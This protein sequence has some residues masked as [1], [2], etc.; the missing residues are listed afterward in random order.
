MASGNSGRK[1][2]LDVL[3]ILAS[4][5]VCYN[6]AHGFHY[7]L[8]QAAD[9]S[10]MSWLLVFHSVLIRINIPL[11]FMISGALLFGKEESWKVVL[12]KRVWRFFVLITGASAV[13][14]VVM[15]WGSLSWQDFVYSYLRGTVNG[16]HWYLFAYLGLLLMLPFLRR[17]AAGLTKTDIL[18]LLIMKLIHTAVL[19]VLNFAL[20]HWG[21]GPVALSDQLQLPLIVLDC[22]FYP[23]L[24]YYLAEKVSPEIIGK[25]QAVALIA[26]YV[27]GSL[28]STVVT[29]AQGMTTG[30]TQDYLGLFNC[31]SAMAVFL[32]VR[33]AFEKITV[34][35]KVQ[36][37]LSAVSGA[38]VGIYLLEPMVAKFLYVPFFRFFTWE[39][40][41]MI[42]G[43]L[44]WTVV[45]MATGLAVTWLLR[46]IPGVKR[47][48]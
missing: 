32:L 43:S 38:V 26:L 37:A 31:L 11:F 8:D 15:N 12:H 30:F 7:Y 47:Y 23:L 22:L 25:K 4:F 34:P 18:A 41:S 24:G 29:Y 6:H 9:G 10:L 17:I 14:Y 19:P 3:R 27:G 36:K 45:C 28:I 42:L 40:I 1:I 46:K 20:N 21:I 44:L 35:G 2:Y 48:F 13:T 39:P 33:G 5:L 16:S